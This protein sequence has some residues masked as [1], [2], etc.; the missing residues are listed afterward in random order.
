MWDVR[1]QS[2]AAAGEVK[3]LK[4]Y[5]GKA[6]VSPGS[7]YKAVL[8][9]PE[10]TAHAIII[11]T[12]ERYGETADPLLFELIYAVDKLDGKKSAKGH[13]P[14]VLQPDECPGLVMDWFTEEHRRFELRRRDTTTE[15]K[16][17]RWALGSIRLS[18][19]KDKKSSQ[20]VKSHKDKEYGG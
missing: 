1:S 18:K 2:G 6:L 19:A 15:K 5:A 14:H 8:C 10:A 12:L 4:V 3:S 17:L 13:K 16:G 9:E 7:L 11:K 20:K